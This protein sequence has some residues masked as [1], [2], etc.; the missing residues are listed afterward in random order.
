MSKATRA[1]LYSWLADR[2]I[3]MSD[4]LIESANKLNY[5]AWELV[6]KCKEAK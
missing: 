1:I 4:K 2:L 5:R 3:D 6:G